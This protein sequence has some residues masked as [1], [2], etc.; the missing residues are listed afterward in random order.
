MAHRRG[1]VCKIMQDREELKELLKFRERTLAVA[2]G[3]GLGGTAVSPNDKNMNA[4]VKN[5][6]YTYIYIYMYI[7]DVI[8]SLETHLN[9]IASVSSL[10]EIQVLRLRP[11]P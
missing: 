10:P 5:T 8:M 2:W 7:L 4:R 3:V 6:F 11:R 1:R 9:L